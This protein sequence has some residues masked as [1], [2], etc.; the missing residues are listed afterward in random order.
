MKIKYYCPVW[1]MKHL[2]LAPVLERIKASGYD[3]AEIALNP[4]IQDLYQVR[5]LFEDHGLEFLVQ[6]P[7]AKGDTPAK[8]LRDYLSKLEALL[9]LNPVMI[10]CHTGKDYFTIG[11][12]LE[13]I[14]GADA[15]SKKYNVTVAHEIHRGRFSFS[16]ALI[17][18]YIS[19][20]PDLKL[21]ADFSHWCVVSESLLEDQQEIMDKVIPHCVYIHARVGYAQGPQVPHPGAPEY[22]KELRQ[23]TK[24]WQQIVAHHRQTQKKELIITCEHGPAPYMHTLPFT[25]QPVA[26]QYEVNLFMKNYLSQK[27]I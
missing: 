22:E 4:E 25:D 27:L 15:L 21:T 16:T 24:W 1:G 19:A 5:Q 9:K 11:Q 26:S 8:M 18:K 13:F 3:G 17:E 23:H 20:F 10:N 7:Y 2:P 14:N 12:N 6:H